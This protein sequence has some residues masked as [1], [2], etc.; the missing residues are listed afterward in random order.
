MSYLTEKEITEYRNIAKQIRRAILNM[1]YRTKS[2]HIGSSLSMVEILVALY[3]RILSIDP[4]KS[5]DP[6]RDRFVLSKGHGCPALYATLAQRGF[7]SKDV[8]DRFAVDNGSLEQ[9]PTRDISLGIE[10]S[11]GS[12]GHGLSL[13]AGMAIAAKYDRY[14]YR[15]FVF[16]GDGELDEGSNW[17][18]IMF[19]AHHELDN[20]VAIVDYNKLQILG[21]TSE[22]LNLEPLADKWRSFGW[23]VRE[24]DGHDFKQII[25]TLEKT[26]FL[27]RKPSVVI[28]HTV[29]GRG[30]SFMEDKLCW[31]DKYPDEEEYKKALAELG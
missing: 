25:E 27:S 11:S 3:F 14:S 29:K 15:V 31:H 8:L 2:P 18:T 10:I 26:P 23:A 24:I 17:E 20:L 13:G 28:A 12:L 5:N 1:I 6:N 22:V 30:I 19:A 9:H 7:F 16:L 4:K 21:R